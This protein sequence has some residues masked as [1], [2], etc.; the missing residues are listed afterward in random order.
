MATYLY[1]VLAPPNPEAIPNGLTGISGSP[2]R[3]LVPAATTHMEVWV[4]TI[5]DAALRVSGEALARQALLHN[6]VV[7]A[8]LATGR[9]P[10]PARFGSRFD[11]DATCIADVAR[12]SSV[13]SAILDRVAGAVEMSVLIVPAGDFLESIAPIAKPER[14]EAAAG[15]RYL[16]VLRDRT[17]QAED[18]RQAAASEAERLAKAL[19]G[20]VSG[21]SR[22]FRASGVMSVAHLVPLEK[23][24][25][26]RYTLSRLE[27]GAGV[28]YV[29]G[30]PRGPYSFTG[31][32]GDVGGHDSSSLNSN[33]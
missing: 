13:L 29:I 21:E 14:H 33:E 3:V 23:V 6:D 5:D 19:S 32:N 9:T 22:S 24:E 10:L 25:T 18:Q 20:I 30:G 7:D 11:D 12:R 8:A 28:R 26:Y 27:P 15:R 1:C 31:Q 2:V 16:E 4:A 17:R